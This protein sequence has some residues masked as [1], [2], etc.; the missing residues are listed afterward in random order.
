MPR[1]TPLFTLSLAATLLMIGVGMI[2][3]LLPRR[4]LD[5]SGSLQDVGYIASA[6][7]ISYLLLQLPVG[8]LADRLGVKPFLLLGYVL[9]GLSG[10]IYVAAGSA[11]FIFLGRFIQGAGEAPIWAL[12]PALLSLAYPHARGRAI[13]IYNAAIHLGLTLGPLLGIFLFAS[14]GGTTPFLIFAGLCFAG[15]STLLFLQPAKAAATGHLVE[16]TPGLRQL[17]QILKAREPRLTLYGIFLYG[18]GYGI[19]VSVLPA[20]LSVEKGFDQVGVGV[21][22]ALF[23]VAISASQLVIGPL[24]DRRGRQPYMIAGLLLVALGFASFIPLPYP[25]TYGPLTLASFGLGV[26]CVAS[27]AYL[28]ESVPESLRATVSGAYYL[29]WGFGYFSG[30]MIVGWS[31]TLFTASVGYLLYGGAAAVVALLFLTKR[32][33]SVPKEKA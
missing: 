25:W 11:E 16:Q 6:F 9:C 4:V 15:A 23:Y 21:F 22:F 29:A 7:A 14:G 28:T 13:G 17:A 32:R 5:F 12:G 27:L 10:L 8:R 2:V 24:S 33:S 18:A 26:F 31:E 20:S 1:A 19:Y 3:A 30:P